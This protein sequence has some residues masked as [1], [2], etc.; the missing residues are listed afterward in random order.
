MLQI[1]PASAKHT[2]QHGSA[3]PS[4]S[5]QLVHPLQ[6]GK[7]VVCIDTRLARLIELVGEDVQHKFTV[8]LSV[9]VSVSLVV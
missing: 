6:R 8:A 9:D 3:S 7:A 2:S 5:T 4:A 1:R